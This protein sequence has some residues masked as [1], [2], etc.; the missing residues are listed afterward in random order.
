MTMKRQRSRGR[1]RLRVWSRLH[2]SCHRSCSVCW[3]WFSVGTRFLYAVWPPSSLFAAGCMSVFLFFVNLVMTFQPGVPLFS[4][5]LSMDQLLTQWILVLGYLVSWT[6][7]WLERGRQGRTQRGRKQRVRFLIEQGGSYREV[8]VDAS[9][10]D[11]VMLQM[12]L[13]ELQ[14]Q[15]RWMRLASFPLNVWGLLFLGLVTGL[16]TALAHGM[17]NEMT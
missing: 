1:W 14:P 9:P 16:G 11:L 7:V 6:Q 3:Q 5:L 2:G 12:E 15:S 17:R 8:E 13:G 4:F 10:N